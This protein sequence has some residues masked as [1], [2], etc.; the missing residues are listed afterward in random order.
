MKRERERV[1][2]RDFVCV[3]GVSKSGMCACVSEKK[4]THTNRGRTS[5]SDSVWVGGW[6]CLS[7]GRERVCVCMCERES[8]CVCV[9]VC[10]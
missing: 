7:V 9:C 5:M 3:V 6:V 8:E 4:E 2:A 10:V 1:S